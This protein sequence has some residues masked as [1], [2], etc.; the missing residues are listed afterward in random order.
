MNRKTFVAVLVTLAVTVACGGPVSPTALPI[1]SLPGK[2]AGGPLLT[3]TPTPIQLPSTFTFVPIE[4]MKVPSEQ[5]PVWPLRGQTPADVQMMSFC[6]LGV[7]GPAD[8]NGGLRPMRKPMGP[9]I[10][11]A[12]P[13]FSS[14]QLQILQ[15]GDG[16]GS[17]VPLSFEMGQMTE[18]TPTGGRI[19][20]VYDPLYTGLGKSATYVEDGL[21]VGARITFGPR[22]VF[23]NTFRHELGHTVLGLCHHNLPGMMSGIWPADS[24]LSLVERDNAYAMSQLRAGTT[25]SGMTSSSSSR[26]Y[27]LVYDH[28]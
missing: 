22:G 15:A 26:K 20:V 18:A 12:G 7:T 17:N 1:T 2:S 9:M 4:D 6:G 28:H 23:T 11:V 16:L 19:Y 24:A 14:S 8:E 21:I 5:L 25:W 27:T 10:V 3:P 13:G